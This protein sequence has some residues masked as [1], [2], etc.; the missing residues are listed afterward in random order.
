MTNIMNN[1]TRSW[2]NLI[3][4]KIFRTQNACL[5][6]EIYQSNRKKKNEQL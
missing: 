2:T 4:H 6:S 1:K 3:N 5:I